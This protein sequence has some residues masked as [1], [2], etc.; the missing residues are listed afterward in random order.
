[1]GRLKNTILPA[2]FPSAAK[3]SNS[4]KDL[5]SITW[6]V[7]PLPRSPPGVPTLPP[8]AVTL[9]APAFPNPRTVAFSTPRTQWGFSG[10]DCTYTESSPIC[11]NRF[12]AHA[13]AFAS[14]ALH[15][16]RG[17]TSAHKDCN[18]RYPSWWAKASVYIARICLA[19]VA[20]QTESVGIIGWPHAV[21]AKDSTA[22]QMLRF[23]RSM[24]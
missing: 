14:P 8:K 7:I 20:C 23:F 17:P 3:R 9:S 22:N 12:T 1:M 19:A 18:S 21:P 10:T 2:T 5:T 11:S 24:G 16:G 15:T 13:M 4:A 6:A